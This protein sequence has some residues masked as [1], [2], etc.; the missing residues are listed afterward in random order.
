M[1]RNDMVLAA[2]GP[3]DAGSSE[4]PNLLDSVV[5]LRN[6][7]CTSACRD[8]GPEAQLLVAVQRGLVAQPLVV[9]VRILVEVVVIRVEERRV[10]LVDLNGHQSSV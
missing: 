8:S 5:L 6:P 4:T 9:R 2:C 1:A 7:W 3:R 10:W